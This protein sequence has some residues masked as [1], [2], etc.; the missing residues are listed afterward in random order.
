MNERATEWTNASIQ[1]KSMELIR[2]GSP[3][4]LNGMDTLCGFY[5]DNGA[6]MITAEYRFNQILSF[7]LLS[8]GRSVCYPKCIRWD[9]EWNHRN[10]IF[11]YRTANR[12]SEPWIMNRKCIIVSGS[13]EWKGQ[14]IQCRRRT[15]TQTHIHLHCNAFL[16]VVRFTM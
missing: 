5:F 3:P 4:I 12:R 7:K 10:S 6:K 8:T 1:C 2:H 16:N 13:N 14:R 9:W 15:N 11:E